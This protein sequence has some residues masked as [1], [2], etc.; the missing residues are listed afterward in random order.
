[1][2]AMLTAAGLGK[3]Y[4]FHWALKPLDLAFDIGMHGLLGPNG[5]GKTT[6]MRMLAGV[7]RPTGRG[8]AE[9]DGH[10]VLQG[11]RVK[12]RI[13]FVPQTFHMY[14]SL[15]A[16]EWLTH[17]GRLKGLSGS[18]LAAAVQR[19]LEDVSL[20]GIAD[21]PAKTYSG[22]M[23]KRLGIAQALIGDPDIIIADEPTTGLD[24]EER[25]KL[26]N[27]L[28]TVSLTRTVLLST[29]VLGD[30]QATCRTVTV[31]NRG[32]LAYCGDLAGLSQHG[33]GVIWTWEASQPEW[34]Q[35]GNIEMLSARLT[36]EGIECR[37]LALEAPTPYAMLA[38]PTPEDGYIA[39]LSRN[40]H[41]TRGL[42]A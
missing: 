40:K 28:A 38:Q 35:Y 13:G 16:R 15:T 17:A 26:R 32:Q 42:F 19:T 37:A 11:S 39:L 34:Q 23:V 5:A 9:L 6:L 14:P 25:V 20:T 24:P 3:R 41:E 18:E 22:G 7:L 8:R 31:L 36:P 10:P 33:Q 21:R 4:R 29:H 30:I 1:M 27:L 2:I 12:R